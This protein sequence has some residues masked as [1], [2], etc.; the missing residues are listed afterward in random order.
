[1]KAVVLE[2]D[3]TCPLARVEGPMA[4]RGISAEIVAPGEI[5]SLEEPSRYDLAIVLGSDDSAY[6]DS[7]PWVPDELAYVRRAIES[8]VPVLGIC[9]GAQMLAR[10]LGA[11]VRKADAPEVGWKTMMRAEVAA[12]MPPGP[13]LTW[14]QDT[15]DWPPGATPLAWTDAS[16][17]AFSHGRHLGLQFHPEATADIIEQWLEVDRRT[18]ALEGVDHDALLAETRGQDGQAGEAATILFER[19]FDQLRG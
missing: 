12:W 10:A 3:P 9:F 18:L 1:M 5:G 7:V 8:D 2:N 6:D 16:P 4:A 17:Q 19:Y 11:E 14:H 13:W 15:F